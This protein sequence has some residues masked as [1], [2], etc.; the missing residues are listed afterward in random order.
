MND[1]EKTSG[2]SA[3]VIDEEI[4]MPFN[5]SDSTLSVLV[6]VGIYS[7]ELYANNGQHVMTTT[8]TEENQI[9]KMIPFSENGELD[10][11]EYKIY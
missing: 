4:R 3:E 1:H 5:Y 2:M 7:V 9:E 11:V 8:F 10:L 6:V